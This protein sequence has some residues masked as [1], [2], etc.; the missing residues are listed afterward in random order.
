MK[1]FIPA[2]SLVLFFTSSCNSQNSSFTLDHVGKVIDTTNFRIETIAPEDIVEASKLH[3]LTLVYMWT[4]WCVPSKK[5]IDGVLMPLIDSLGSSGVLVLLVAASMEEDKVKNILSE[6]KYPIQSYMIH[7]QKMTGGL[8]DKN[9]M[10]KM[11]QKVAALSG[12]KVS[13]PFASPIIFMLD[14]SGALIEF[15]IGNSYETIFRTVETNL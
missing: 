9:A 13:A 7:G 2:L 5:N 6:K 10:K 8:F 12:K 1:T 4:T 14:S 3:K 11:S 15:D